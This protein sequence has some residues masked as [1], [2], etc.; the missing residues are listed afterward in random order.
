MSL[1]LELS[2]LFCGVLARTL[3]PY[4]RKLKQGRIDKFTGHGN[5]ISGKVI[6][7]KGV[8]PAAVGF[9]LAGDIAGTALFSALKDHVLDKMGYPA[10]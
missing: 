2:G 7:G 1:I 9:N 6:A 3:L 5:F 8:H 4:M 10:A